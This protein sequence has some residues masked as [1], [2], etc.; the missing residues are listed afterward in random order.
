MVLMTIGAFFV[1]NLFI[2]VVIA[3]YNREKERL[4]NDHLITQSQKKWLKTKLLVLQSSPKVFFPPPKNKVRNLFYQ[5][6]N[7][8]YYEIAITICITLNTVLMTIH[9]YDISKDLQAKIDLGNYCFTFIFLVEAV[10]KIAGLGFRY[11]LDSWNI[12]DFSI[13]VISIC[14]LILVSFNISSFARTATLLRAFR[15]GRIFKILR[16][17]KSLR[18]IF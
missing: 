3:T 16:K 17:N 14:S 2:G 18:V 8:K 11:F 7:S 10:C 5:M 9:W 12:F 6:A 15:L 4:G 1:A 13:V